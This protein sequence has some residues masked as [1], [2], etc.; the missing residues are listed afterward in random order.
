VIPAAITGASL[1]VPSRPGDPSLHVLGGISRE[2][3]GIDAMLET[4]I[5]ARMRRRLTRLGAMVVGGAI[6]ALDDAGLGDPAV[7]TDIAS[8]FGTSY[9][10]IAV[11]CRIFESG[12]DAGM[13]PTA[14]HNSVH[15]AALGYLCMLTGLRGPSLS[16]SDSMLSGEESV[17]E[18]VVLL[19]EGAASA[20]VAGSGDESCPSMF[21]PC[22]RW[23][24]DA[25]RQTARRIESGDRLVTDEGCGFIVL[26]G[27]DHAA[28]R[29]AR[30]LARIA[31]IARGGD[32]AS[33]L[34][35]VA[36]GKVDLV[37]AP[38][39]L[40]RE[41]DPGVAAAVREVLG[42]DVEIASEGTEFG[43]VP[44]SGIIRCVLG[45]RRLGEGAS[46][47]IVAGIDLDGHAAAI[48]LSRG[49]EG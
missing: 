34:G 38:A 1:V 15:N 7:Q 33:A 24:E 41:T 36:P 20:V 49:G 23:G 6:S 45:L 25:P 17:A 8:I 2:P 37:I 28:R 4:R 11:A 3:L 27:E 26:E 47:V 16:I 48:R 9:G 14:F 44:A 5:H 43:Y 30:V 10:E 21:S 40:D 18:A 13:S 31:D 35:R 22:W 42:P 46:T 19:E 39:G 12:L 29:Q 32:L